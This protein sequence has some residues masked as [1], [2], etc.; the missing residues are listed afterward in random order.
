MFPKYDLITAIKFASHAAGKN[1][2]QRYYFNGVHLNIQGRELVVTAT[3]GHRLARVRLTAIET[4]EAMAQGE[5]IIE[6][7]SVKAL[8]SV[9]KTRKTDE[10]TL[11]IKA[12]GPHRL[13]VSDG[14]ST[15]ALA[16]IDSRYP[17]VTRALPYA[18]PTGAPLLGVNVAYLAEASAALNLVA[19]PKYHG[20]KLETWDEN[21]GLRL[22]AATNHGDFKTITEPA[23]VYVA[24]M[25][26]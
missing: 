16:C 8:L 19:N 26:L 9:F 23:V 11:S 18:E 25:R 2:A 14:N 6:N 24:Q 17:D 5:Y 15:Q 4:D 12:A 13:E 21:T 7:A 10:S 3:D 22:T 1:L 20:A